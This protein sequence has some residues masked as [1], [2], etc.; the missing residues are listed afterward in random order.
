MKIVYLRFI[1]ILSHI[2]SWSRVVVGIAICYGMNGPGFEPRQGWDKLCY[3]KPSILDRGPHP[4]SSSVGTGIPSWQ[5]KRPGLEV[6]CLLPSSAEVENRRN[7]TYAFPTCVYGVGRDSFTF[8]HFL[9]DLQA[10][11]KKLLSRGSTSLRTLEVPSSDM[12]F[13]C[14]FLSCKANARLKPAKTGHGPH[15]S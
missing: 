5:V 2:S 15:S 10:V 13:P 3:P 8:A 1:L 9:V 6:D 7:Y 11:T 14:F 4:A 12:V